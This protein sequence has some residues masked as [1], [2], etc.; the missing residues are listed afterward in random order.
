[1]VKVYIVKPYTP[2]TLCFTSKYTDS[3]GQPLTKLS[4]SKNFLMGFLSI[5]TPIIV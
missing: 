1:M 4:L 2:N 3:A 5:G